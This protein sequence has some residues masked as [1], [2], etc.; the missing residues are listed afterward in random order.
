[1]KTNK[2]SRAEAMRYAKIERLTELLCKKDCGL[3][4][5]SEGLCTPFKVGSGITVD[6]SS[7][8]VGKKTYDAMELKR[9]TINT[10][11]SLSVY[12]RSGK[13]LCGWR[14][15]NLS[16]E[17]IELF[18]MWVRKNG[19]PAE[20]VSGMGERTLLLAFSVVTAIIIALIK[21]LK[22]FYG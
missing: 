21:I 5:A 19:I 17:N 2:M 12:D 15:L 20:A 18:C 3:D 6:G 13:K 9:V 4:A 11:G 7:L 14:N 16:L 1:M 10:E 8:T 22:Y